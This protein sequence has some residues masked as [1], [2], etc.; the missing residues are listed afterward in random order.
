MK[1]AQE[2]R[3]APK[4]PRRS[5]GGR[6]RD[7]AIAK[8]EKTWN[9]TDAKFAALLAKTTG[10]QTRVGAVGPRPWPPSR[11]Y[12]LAARNAAFAEI[13]AERRRAHGERYASKIIRDDY[14]GTSKEFTMEEAFNLLGK[15]LPAAEAVRKAHEWP[16]VAFFIGLRKEVR[17]R[18]AAARAS[19][20]P[21]SCKTEGRA[22]RCVRGAQT[23][24]RPASPAARLVVRDRVEAGGRTSRRAPAAHGAE[25]A[26]HGGAAVLELARE[27]A[28]ARRD[29]LDLRRERVAAR[30]RADGAVVA[31]R[32]VLRAA[33]VLGR[34][35]GADLGEAG[36][37]DDLEEACA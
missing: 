31:A 29:V 17:R 6:Q 22:R 7:E 13:L 10:R 35:H 30:D 4:P 24:L 5:G 3:R 23:R 12:R 8:D 14:R 1:A 26:E 9:R 27:G 16:P 36:E 19:G 21:R 25:R 18:Y 11:P 33:R 15:P 28:V 20:L 32:E 2:E 34:G 37:R